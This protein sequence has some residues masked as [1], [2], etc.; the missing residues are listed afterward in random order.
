MTI[1]IVVETK[2]DNIVRFGNYETIEQALNIIKTLKTNIV[3]KLWVEE[4]LSAIKSILYGVPYKT[5]IRYFG[6]E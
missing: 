2:T 3:N 5:V 1:Q 6:N 4:E